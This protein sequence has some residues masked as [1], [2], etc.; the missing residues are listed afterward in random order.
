[1]I[2]YKDANGKA[3]SPVY[4]KTLHNQLS[5][6]F[7]HA[8]K[9]Y[10]LNVNPAAKVGNMGKAKNKEMLFWTKD[11]YH[12]FADAMMDNPKAVLSSDISPF[13]SFWDSCCHV[14]KISNME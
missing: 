12:K 14:L 7:N 2:N 1:M 11:E 10:G 6:I 5:C 4:L 9:Y 13:F 8:V 3:Y